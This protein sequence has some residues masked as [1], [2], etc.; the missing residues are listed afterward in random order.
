MLVLPTLQII[1]IQ[2]VASDQVF[3]ETKDTEYCL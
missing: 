1:N 3:T 2:V